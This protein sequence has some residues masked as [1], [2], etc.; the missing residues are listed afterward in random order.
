M[1][2]WWR[3]GLNIKKWLCLLFMLRQDYSWINTLSLNLKHRQIIKNDTRDKIYSL[4]RLL[5]LETAASLCI[6]SRQQREKEKRLIETKTCCY[7]EL[8][9]DP[10]VIIWNCINMSKM[11]K[12]NTNVRKPETE[13]L[14]FSGEF[15]CRL[16]IQEKGK[17]TM[18]MERR[19]GEVQ[20]VRNDGK[21]LGE[22]ILWGD[23]GGRHIERVSS[24]KLKIGE[25]E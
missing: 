6:R 25:S 9:K 11:P 21:E 24:P 12:C 1:R 22:H 3:C 2:T 8:L 4:W 16:H 10:Y 7:F 18:R 23:A 17:G 20:R 5:H 19:D 14:F 13:S 15:T